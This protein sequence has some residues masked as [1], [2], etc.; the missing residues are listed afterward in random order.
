MTL[1]FTEISAMVVFL[2][3]TSNL[4]N[5][6]SPAIRL[7][8]LPLGAIIFSYIFEFIGGILLNWYY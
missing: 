5:D 2:S 4:L 7:T 6:E 1:L 8:L 3:V